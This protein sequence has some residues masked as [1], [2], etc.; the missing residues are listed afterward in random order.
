[1]AW[2]PS[3]CT[4]PTSPW[5][6]VPRQT[7]SLTP[8]SSALR[9]AGRSDGLLEQLGQRIQYVEGGQTSL[10]RLDL[11]DHPAAGDGDVFASSLLHPV[12][13]SP[14]AENVRRLT[15]DRTEEVQDTAGLRLVSVPVL[16]ES[17]QPKAVGDLADLNLVRGVSGGVRPA[18]Y[19]TAA[20]NVMTS[21]DN[22]SGLFVAPATTD[23][24]LVPGA[25]FFWHWF[26]EDAP[27]SSDDGGG[28]SRSYDLGSEAFELA[29][30]GVPVDDALRNGPHV[31]TVGTQTTDGI[32]L[33]GNPYPYPLR[34]NG[35]WVEEGTLHTTFA[36]WDP[37]HSTYENLYAGSRESDVLPVW[38]GAVAEVTRTGGLLI[39]GPFEIFSTSHAVDPTAG[40]PV[41]SAARRRTEKAAGLVEF[42]L[43]GTLTDG[44]SVTDRA[45]HVRFVGGASAGWD[46]Y[47]GSKLAAPVESFALVAPVGARQGIPHRNRVLSL[48]TLL[49]SPRT[50][51]LAFTSSDGG[52]FVLRWNAG[53][54]RADW[55][56]TLYDRTTGVTIDLRDRDAY[57]FR[58]SESTPWAERFEV[59]V[60][61]ASTPVESGVTRETTVGDPYPNP[62]A[63][64]VRLDVRAA[65]G[66]RVAADVYDA[67]GRRVM[68]AFEATVPAGRTSTIRVDTSQLAPGLYI[69]RVEGETFAETRRVV[70]AR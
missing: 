5:G 45:A 7:A 59:V 48:P 37:V 53:G 60:A 67:L 47:D 18:Q 50:I 69:V 2:E 30:E 34:L 4:A 43:A 42:E 46:R 14:G 8:S 3:L 28:T 62:A 23:E 6:P 24:P 64:R 38:A 57:S 19:P 26:D 63:G 1:M 35:V 65:T 55:S 25:G 29:A 22:A 21:Y 32:Y 61:P 66:Q 11:A 52:S 13:A 27:P 41:E 68:R 16:D 44:T 10:Q 20:P 31:R 51:P 9:G 36:V 58:T 70:V 49:L 15:V 39:D 12:A 40:V 33:I 54:L 17:G 56:A